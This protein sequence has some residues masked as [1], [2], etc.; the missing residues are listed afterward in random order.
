M[1]MGGLQW[2]PYPGPYLLSPA[3]TILGEQGACD[4]YLYRSEVSIYNLPGTVVG[5]G[6]ATRT[7]PHREHFTGWQVQ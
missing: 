1:A 6:D 4:E 3:L 5:T 2:G 7:S